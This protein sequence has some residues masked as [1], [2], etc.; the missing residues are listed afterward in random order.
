MKQRSKLL[1][2]IVMLL[3]A[4]ASLTSCSKKYKIIVSTQD[5][6]FGLDA[7]SQTLEITANCK[8]TITKNDDADWYSLSMVEGKND[9][10][11]TVTVEALED[12]DFRGA[13]F[14]INSPGGHVTRTVFVSQNKLDFDGLLNKVFGVTRL[15]HWNTD[16]FGM[17][18]EDSYRD[19]YYDPFDTLTGYQMWFL[20]NG[21]GYQ[22]DHHTDTI[23]WWSFNYEYDVLNQILYISFATIDDSP[24][25]YA[26]HVLTASDSLFRIFHEYKTDFWERAD[27]R[28]I[29]TIIPDSTRMEMMRKA[30]KRKAGQPMFLTD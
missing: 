21:E 6:W 20:A 5:L 22:R 30:S 14:V 19:H 24:E 2:M 27:M 18:I 7:S 3:V 12:A 11:I 26:P 28:K 25:D 16:F 9:A 1:I 4:T 8:W 10:T 13:S 29:A 17:I 23:A 15:E